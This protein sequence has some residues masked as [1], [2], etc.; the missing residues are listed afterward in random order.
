M[1]NKKLLALATGAAL[2]VGAQSGFAG[3]ASN[4]ISYQITLSED[5]TVGFGW[6][7][8]FGNYLI[9]SP[10]LTGVFAGQAS[11]HCE[12]GIPYVIVV[13][14]GMNT[15][16]SIRRMYDGNGAY[17]EYDLMDANGNLVGDANPVDPAYTPSFNAAPWAD[18]ISGIGS[19]SLDYYSLS[20]DIFI[21]GLPA[22]SYTDQ[23]GVTVTW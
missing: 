16:G 3:V 15:D 22:G 5:C 8:H 18:G 19:G 6:G 9:D 11:V 23:V 2:L 17:M 14:G 21:A 20:A 7:V 1:M 13:D 12:A 4:S 10:D